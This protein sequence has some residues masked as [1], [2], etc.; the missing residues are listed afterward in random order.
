MKISSPIMF[1]HGGVNLVDMVRLD[2]CCGL[3]ANA[4]FP[5]RVAMFSRCCTAFFPSISSIA[6]FALM[7]ERSLFHGSRRLHS[8]V[9]G[10]R[11]GLRYVPM[12][13]I[14]PNCLCPFHLHTVLSPIATCIILSFLFTCHL[15]SQSVSLLLLVGHQASACPK[16]GTPTW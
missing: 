6:S 8:F 15:P 4:C 1:W 5:L 16:A 13:Y 14:P 12:N 9:P 2:S 3:N 10:F 7:L 11:S